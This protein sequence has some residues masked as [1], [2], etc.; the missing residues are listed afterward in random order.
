MVTTIKNISLIDRTR[1]SRHIYFGDVTYNPGGSCGP[2]I[3]QDYQLVIVHQGSASFLVDNFEYVVPAGHHTLLI[4][5]HYETIQFSTGD[6]TRHTWTSIHPSLVS[7]ELATQLN[8]LPKIIPTTEELNTLIRLGLNDNPLQSLRSD[9]FLEQLGL[10]I[11]HYCLIAEPLTPAPKKPLPLDIVRT[12]HIIE[13]Q[14]RKPLSIPS[15]ARQI[16]VS[17]N[18]LIRIF[19]IHLKTTPSRYLWEVRLQ[20]GIELLTRTGLRINEIS[21][22]SGFQN[23]FHFS[24]MVKKRTG[25]SPRH[26]RQLRWGTP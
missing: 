20:H 10:S 19:K 24:R 17:P 7:D 2:R 13:E 1:Y 22:R 16:G 3:Q 14:F 12:Q 18:H 25:H 15:L 9:N 4:P 8:T 26:L 21:E 11:L 6:Y 23:P 5:G